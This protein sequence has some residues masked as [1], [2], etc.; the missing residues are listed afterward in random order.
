MT[1][2]GWMAWFIAMAIATITILTVGMLSSADIIRWKR[3]RRWSRRPSRES[4]V[5]AASSIPV[6]E[7]SDSLESMRSDMPN[8]G[9]H[10]S[11]AA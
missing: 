5:A 2:L 10:G 1:D 11:N 7:R 9:S 3:P 4:S 6:P 8:D